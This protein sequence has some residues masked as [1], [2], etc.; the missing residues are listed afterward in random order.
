M[1]ACIRETAAGFFAGVCGLEDRPLAFRIPPYPAIRQ[2]LYAHIVSDHSHR[3][4]S[5]FTALALAP[6]H[7]AAEH[8]IHFSCPIAPD[9][10]R[11]VDTE[12]AEFIF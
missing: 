3:S 6:W 5:L 7:Q 1:Y 11:I 12:F 4:E 10:C 9:L 8:K 2:W